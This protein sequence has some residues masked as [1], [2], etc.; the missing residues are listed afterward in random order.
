MAFKGGTMLK[1]MA[2]SA[3]VEANMTADADAH[4]QR[5]LATKH[6]Q[7]KASVHIA[8]K[9]DV[10]P[11]GYARFCCSL[12]HMRWISKDGTIVRFFNHRLDTNDEVL[13]AEIRASLR[14]GNGMIWEVR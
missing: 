7:E 3:V 14:A 10:L 6:A 9:S 1:D 8:A 5:D 4:V 12:E 11:E 2:T 13:I